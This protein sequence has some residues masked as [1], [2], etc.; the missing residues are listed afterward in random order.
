M[1]KNILVNVIVSVIVVILAFI[2]FGG[3][4]I[5]EK[6]IVEKQNQVGAIPGDTV[7]TPC[8]TINGI[9]RCY[10][11]VGLK[12]ATTTPGAI[13]TPSASSTLE[14]ASCEVSNAT[15]TGTHTLTIAKNTSTLSSPPAATTTLITEKTVP[16]ADRWFTLTATSSRPTADNTETL[17]APNTWI[18]CGMHGGTVD[19]IGGFAPKGSFQAEFILTN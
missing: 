7:N 17:F 3:K 15:T 13:K 5:V 11:K 2:L 16:A 6:V 12:Q 4:T 10:T 9:Q 19:D 1:N 18:V 14:Y 8:F